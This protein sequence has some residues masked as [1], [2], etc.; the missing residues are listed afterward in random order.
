MV[1]ALLAGSHWRLHVCAWSQPFGVDPGIVKAA[2][3]ANQ[4]LARGE[5]A[6]TDNPFISH[7]SGAMDNVQLKSQVCPDT[8]THTVTNECTQ[9]EPAI[10]RP[11][12]RD[13]SLNPH[14]LHVADL[15]RPFFYL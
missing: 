3:R 14:T 2:Q 15:P 10:V 5:M 9:S 13:S 12:P 7:R 4:K 1:L 11:P 6:G 8:H